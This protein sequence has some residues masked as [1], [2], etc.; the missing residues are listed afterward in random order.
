LARGGWGAQEE[1]EEKKDVR[2]EKGIFKTTNFEK[3][4]SG[5]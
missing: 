2:R 5:H 1:G 3:Y 4:S